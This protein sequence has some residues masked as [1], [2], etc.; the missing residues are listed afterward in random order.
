VFAWLARAGRLGALELLRTFNCGIGMIL[1]VDPARV[2]AVRAALEAN[3][4]S[5][6]TIGRIGSAPGRPRV[7]FAGLD[8]AWPVAA[9]RS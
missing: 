1:V 6:S 7:E 3:G 5:V 8:T 2:G 4:E 9:P